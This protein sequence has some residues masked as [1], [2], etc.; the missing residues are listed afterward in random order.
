M[1]TLQTSRQCSAFTAKSRLQQVRRDRLDHRPTATDTPVEQVV[2]TRSSQGI[3]SASAP[4]AGHFHERLSDLEQRQLLL[5]TAT[6]YHG[7]H[8]VSV[9]NRPE[10]DVLVAYLVR[11]NDDRDPVDAIREGRAM[12]IIMDAVGDMKIQHPRRKS[13][14]FWLRWFWQFATGFAR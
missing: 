2:E 5:Q 13:R 8:L 1:A 4:A 12:Q 3:P 6:I 11:N 9:Q 14:P 7:W 10:S